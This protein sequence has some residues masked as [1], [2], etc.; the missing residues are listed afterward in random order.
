MSGLALSDP[1]GRTNRRTFGPGLCPYSKCLKVFEKV[2]PLQKCCRTEHMALWHKETRKSQ[3]E[4]PVIREDHPFAV[5]CKA[6]EAHVTALDR[7][8]WANAIATLPVAVPTVLQR[9]GYAVPFT[10][11]TRLLVRFHLLGK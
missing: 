2:R 6:L 8:L 11:D 1:G 7:S 10:R 3:N 4:R 5:S 9:N